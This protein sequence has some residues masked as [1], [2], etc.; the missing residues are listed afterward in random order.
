[1]DSDDPDALYNLGLTEEELDLVIRVQEATVFAWLESWTLPDPLPERAADI[2]R[3][4]GVVF[5]ALVAESGRLTRETAYRA[6]DGSLVDPFS[7]DAVEDAD[8]P[9]GATAGSSGPSAVAVRRPSD[10]MK[11]RTSAS[12]G[13]GR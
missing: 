7:V 5:D 1:M 13:T 10:H 12:T 8:S 3:M 11:R 4:P 2:G 6:P 9:T